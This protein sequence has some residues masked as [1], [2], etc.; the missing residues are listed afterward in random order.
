MLS[1]AHRHRDAGFDRR[2]ADKQ[3][4]PGGGSQ[5]LIEIS[6]HCGRRRG[7]QQRSLRPQLRQRIF[8]DQRAAGG[9]TNTAP[10]GS[11]ASFSRVI[12]CCAAGQVEA[13][14]PADGNISSS[15]HG[16]SRPSPAP[17]AG[18]CGCGKDRH[19]EA[20]AHCAG[21]GRCGPC[22]RCRRAVMSQPS[23]SRWPLRLTQPHT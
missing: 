17:A 10:F 13:D 1:S 12:V 11:S 9:V 23:M 18:A 8:V 19:V 3:R 20:R 2:G 14:L 15:W 16:G 6:A 5:A 22:R 4:K 7:R 21:R